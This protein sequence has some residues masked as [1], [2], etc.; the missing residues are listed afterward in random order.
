MQ[1]LL[2]ILGI[3]FWLFAISV[4]LGSLGGMGGAL[5]QLFA[6]NSAGFGMIFFALAR[7]LTYWERQA[8]AAERNANE[9]RALHRTIALNAP[10]EGVG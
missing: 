6:L 4:T 10:I 3:V 9:T 5:H 8:E 1:K 7:A 2:F